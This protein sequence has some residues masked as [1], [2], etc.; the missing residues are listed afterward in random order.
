VAEAAATGTAFAALYERCAQRA[1]NLAYRITGSESDA[2]DATQEALLR[3][4]RRLQESEDGEPASDIHLLTATRKACYDLIG[5]RRGT[6]PNDA[7]GQTIADANG[8]LPEH[9]REALALRELEGLS[10]EEIAAI[11][12]M[13]GHSVAQLISRARINLDDELRGTPLATV[14]APSAECE[15]G[16]SLIAA[17]QDDQIEPGSD[18]DTWLAA[19]LNGCERCRLAVEAMQE[20][21]VSYRAWAPIAVVPWLR[22]ETMAQAATLAGA[23]WSDAI[24]SGTGAGRR[25]RRRRAIAAAGL[26]AA[27]LGGGAAVVLAGGE[28]PPIQQREAAAGTHPAAGAGGAKRRSEPQRRRRMRV[29]RRA[30][31]RDAPQ[32]AAMA[33]S[34]PQL[35]PQPRVGEG[36][37]DEP[38]APTAGREGKSGVQPP[39][40][41]ASPKSKPVSAPQPEPV[42]APTEPEA[43]VPAPDEATTPEHPSKGKGP[44][45]GIPAKGKR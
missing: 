36:P 9:Q 21:A 15:R 24:A 8:Q 1:Y 37:Q 25:P 43:P 17:R 14:A 22:E 13:N 18:D 2:A 32:R 20:A 33:A 41:V 23:D 29:R 30:A 11:M 7:A 35:Q 5:K 27:L 16:L 45:A 40:V 28:A 12:E 34:L 38:A 39:R 19:H 4:L 31:R 44:P 6:Q 26:G 10:Y 3:E 42:P